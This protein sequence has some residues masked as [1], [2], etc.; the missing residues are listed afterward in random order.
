MAIPWIAEYSFVG[1]FFAIIICITC[2]SVLRSSYTIKQINLRLYYYALFIITASSIQS[3][4]FHAMIGSPL[5]TNLKIFIF[6]SCQNSVLI[7][8]L[9]LLLVMMEY[10]MNLFFFTRRQRWMS[11]RVW[12]W[13]VVTI[14]LC[15]KFYA[16]LHGLD[17]HLNPE[18]LMVEN[19]ALQDN[20]FIILYV[21]LFCFCAWL[22]LYH[23]KLLIEH[24]FR[25]LIANAFLAFLIIILS[26][27]L[28]VTSFICVSFTLPVLAVLFLFHYNAYDVKMGTLDLKAFRGYMNDKNE[29]EQFVVV[30]LYLK[31][32][33]I[34]KNEVLS[35]NF[36]QYVQSMFN[37]RYDYNLFRISDEHLV[38]VYEVEKNA[39]LEGIL[40]LLQLRI[41]YG[42]KYLYRQYGIPYQLLYTHSVADLEPED[43]IDLSDFLSRQMF[44]NEIKVCADKDIEAYKKYKTIDQIFQDI[45]RSNNL[46]DDRILV[47]YQP[48]M[49]SN[50]DCYKAEALMRL[51]VGETTYYPGDFLPVVENEN[52]SHLITK[53]VLN[54]VCLHIKELE[55]EGYRIDKISINLSTIDLLANEGYKDFIEIVEKRHKMTFDK[56]AFE[57]LEYSDKADYKTL[58][59]TMTAF[60][61][62]SGV[63][64]YLDDFGAGYSNLLRLISLPVKVIKFD[65]DILK[66]VHAAPSTLAIIHSNIQT[67]V[68]AG[69]QILFEGIET[70]EDLAICEKLQVSY[71][72]GFYFARPGELT[73][74]KK[75][76]MKLGS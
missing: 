39:N 28:N 26:T 69:Y 27:I 73:E 1:D 12:T 53:I 41:E 45:Q 70:E 56:I 32:N 25:C 52:Y 6:F 55:E 68:E 11:I 76:L 40:A 7:G 57:L 54:K 5:D 65:K 59:K 29:K 72:Q 44:L 3:I 71:F 15:Y 38:L 63:E 30:N 33:P 37:D 47:Y 31:K 35:Q 24:V 62:I 61:V 10:L 13:P 66:R 2:V 48:I 20:I 8:L 60:S 58:I 9:V 42:L 50:R 23:R 4:V 18:T 67:F 36:L 21:Y 46:N 43:Y 51:K 19:Y 17:I 74:L 34:D 64:F 49:E 14:Y 75:H 16:P 22:I